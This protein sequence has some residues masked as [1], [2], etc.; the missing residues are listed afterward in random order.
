M[1]WL[2]I[3]SYNELKYSGKYTHSMLGL[4]DTYT[5]HLVLC[6][7]ALYI[8]IRVETGLGHLGHDLSMSNRFHPLY[9][10]CRSDQDSAL[11]H[12]SQ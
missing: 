12:M 10:I 9:K 5:H 4:P 11:D 7:Q 2:K 6:S 1:I 8:A 3:T